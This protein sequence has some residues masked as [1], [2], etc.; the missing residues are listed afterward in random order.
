MCPY[1]GANDL[2]TRMDTFP[3]NLKFVQG[4]NSA[5]QTEERNPWV[6]GRDED[7]ACC[8]CG[9]GSETVL[10]GCYSYSRAWTRLEIAASDQDAINIPEIRSCNS[11]CT[12][13]ALGLP[14][15]ALCIGSLQKAV[16]RHYSIDGDDCQ[17]YCD[18]CCSPRRT[19]V[20]V[21]GEIIVREQARN[22][23]GEKLE[24]TQ[25]LCYGP[26]A[27]PTKQEQFTPAARQEAA[28]QKGKAYLYPQ[29][30]QAR[31]QPAKVNR[32]PMHTLE[33]DLA[34]PSRAKQQEHVLGDDVESAAP[35]EPTPHE[36]GATAS[37]IG[38]LKNETGPVPSS[39]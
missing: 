12:Q 15:Y 25:Y 28:P 22:G 24:E 27:Y 20:R 19:L 11:D 18:A 35:T 6:W 4:V 36:L 9:C 37:R 16:R 2:Q 10:C 39:L 5:R 29:T 17:D 23:K 8:C 14:F 33:D 21:E 3:N 7:E 13:F 32:R 26:M 34:T 30:L 31:A 38:P 1:P